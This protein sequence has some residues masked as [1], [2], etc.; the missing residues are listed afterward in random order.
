M[1]E[2]RPA[3]HRVP[4][5]F[6]IAIALT[7]VVLAGRAAWLEI[8][9]HRPLRTFEEGARVRRREALRAYVTRAA[10]G[11]LVPREDVLLAVRQEF[12]QQVLDRSL[13]YRLY[14]ADGRY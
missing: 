1:S 3:R 11:S 9:S 7:F 14:F 13:P 2:T 5:P 8:A 6:A 10:S 4:R 12:M